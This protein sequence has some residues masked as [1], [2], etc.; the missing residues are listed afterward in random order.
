MSKDTKQVVKEL[1]EWQEAT[2]EILVSGFLDAKKAHNPGQL[3]RELREANV[4][5]YLESI[6]LAD[7]L[8]K[9]LDK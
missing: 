1:K 2:K 5:V 4:L 6:E 7:R 3:D 9:V 8:L